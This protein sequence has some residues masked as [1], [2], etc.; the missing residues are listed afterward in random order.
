MFLRE[1]WIEKKE[2]KKKNLRF[3]EFDIRRR[4]KTSEVVF[5]VLEDKVN[6]VRGSGCDDSFESHDVGVVE[7]PKN[8]D[9]ASHEPNALRLKIVEPH[10]LQGNHSPGF[11]LPR[12]EHTAIRPLPDL[13]KW[14][15]RRKLLPLEETK[16]GVDNKFGVAN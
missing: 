2:R 10:L 3:G 14:P 11:N 5:H 9:L 7:P 15:K 6:A 4:N 8:C 13:H 1:E 12:S 16:N